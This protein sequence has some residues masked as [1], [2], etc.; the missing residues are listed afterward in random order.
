MSDSLRERCVSE[1]MKLIDESGLEHLS[2]RDVARRLSVSHQAPYKHFAN[3]EH[4][5]AAAAAKAYEALA[6]RIR[7]RT[8]KEDPAE[9]LFEIG[10]RYLEFARAHPSTY[11]LLFALS[12]KELE[13]YADVQWH[14]EWV[15]EELKNAISV[16]TKREDRA[17]LDAASHFAWGAIHGLASL[18]SHR[19]GSQGAGDPDDYAEESSRALKFIWSS[20]IDQSQ[21]SSPFGA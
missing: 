6:E 21:R 8:R 19:R 10:L 4:L 1:A 15:R 7:A 11:R 5:L 9:D 13:S 17:F 12:Q 3:R 20:I 16:L 2:L 14:A 18:E